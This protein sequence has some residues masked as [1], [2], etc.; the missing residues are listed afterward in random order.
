MRGR[1]SLE[2]QRGEVRFIAEQDGAIEQDL[3]RRLIEIFQNTNTVTKAYLAAVDYGDLTTYSVALCL[4]SP[5]KPDS[6]L[7][8]RIGAVFASLFSSDEHLDIL[9]LNDEQ[10]KRLQ[11]VCPAFY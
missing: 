1:P 6:A 5:S 10:E 7:V 4:R 9:F 3:K 8:D 11:S 2:L